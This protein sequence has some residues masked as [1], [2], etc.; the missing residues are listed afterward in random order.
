MLKSV[1]GR[2]FYAYDQDSPFKFF[3]IGLPLVVN[4]VFLYKHGKRHI[5]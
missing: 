1:R 5:V 2:D 4:I 3:F